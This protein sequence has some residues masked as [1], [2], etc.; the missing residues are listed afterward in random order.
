M[1]VTDATLPDNPITFVNP[2]F[3]ELS[4]YT[5]EEL[6]GQNP[7]FMNGSETDP[8]AIAAYE[9]AM[10]EG[11]DATLEILQY[12]KDGSPFRAMLF[13]TPLDDG[14]GRVTNHF[15]S[16][17]DITR[18]HEAEQALRTLATDM[19]RRV[20][21]RT[22]TLEA[23]NAALHQADA[24]REML[25]IEVNHRAKNS[26]SVGAALLQ[27]QGRRQTDQAVR[28]LFEESAERLNAMARVHD[29]LS[30]S[31][32]AQRVDVATYVAE[33][34]EALKSLAGGDGRISLRARTEED[35]LIDADAA[36]PIGIVLTELIT[37]AVKYAFPDNRSGMILVQAKRSGPGR[38]EIVV[39][40]NGVGMANF[41]EGSLG[42]GLIRSLV[43][44]IG[45]ELDIQGD[46]GVTV[47]IS[48]SDASRFPP[49]GGREATEG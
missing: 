40:D 44:Q 9:T 46:A 34:C 1:M 4:G 37:N 6:L 18:R 26:L 38:V 47:T 17:L 41:R 45:G 11:R 27:L 14:Q 30:R 28:A 21:E 5:F 23:A 35:I 2:A 24:E 15:L 7:H 29:M 36:F 13:A 8:E 39:R 16:Y 22:R 3:V 10:Q 31:E 25:L 12:R 49:P 19:E 48:F 42:Y 33:L 32:H 43:K 20:E